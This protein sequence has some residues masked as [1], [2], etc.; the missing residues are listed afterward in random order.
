MLTMSIDKIK[1]I[2]TNFIVFYTTFDAPNLNFYYT[3][4][5][6]MVN[7]IIRQLHFF[8]FYDTGV[9]EFSLW[10]V[11]MR[12][13]KWVL[14]TTQFYMWFNV[15][16]FIHWRIQRAC[17]NWTDSMCHKTDILKKFKFKYTIRVPL[18]FKKCSFIT[19]KFDLMK[20]NHL[21]SIWN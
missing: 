11:L 16:Q 7:C 14:W 5:Q 8:L 1:D 13:N 3:I 15:C 20:Q 12:N 4:S 10:S 9:V 18:W 2:Y 21:F 6:L 17:R 19:Q